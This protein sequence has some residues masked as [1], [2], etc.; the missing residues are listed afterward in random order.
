VS[1]FQFVADHRH[2]FEV[3]RLCE[4]VQV[5]RSSF[6]AWLGAAPTRAARVA[7]DAELA[8]RIRR[9]HEADRTQGVSRIT[10]ELNDGAPPSARV[11]HKRVARGDA[12]P[13][14]REG[15]GCAAG[16]AP[17]SPSLPISGCLIC[18]VGTSPPLRPT[19]ATSAIS[20]TSRSPTARTCTW[21]R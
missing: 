7:A 2:A 15:C 5:A 13:R 9:V 8:D 6:Y 16:S 11:N 4:L 10:A 1:R 18:C 14:H 20:L 21:R 19:S 12:R 3:K 17:P